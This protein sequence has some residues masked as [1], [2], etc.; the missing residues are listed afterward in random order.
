MIYMIARF[1]LLLV[2]SMGALF[3]FGCSDKSENI[4]ID[5]NNRQP[6]ATKAATESTEAVLRITIAGVI[7]PTETLT[8]LSKW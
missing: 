1:T 4:K 6:I 7:S 8:S 3:T 2:L 5:L